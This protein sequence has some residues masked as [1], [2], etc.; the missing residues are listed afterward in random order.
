MS[1]KIDD[2]I[3][4]GLRLYHDG[5]FGEAETAGD[6]ICFIAKCGGQRDFDAL[7]LWVKEEIRKRIESYKLTRS[8]SILSSEGSMD[9]AEV[10]EIFIRRIRL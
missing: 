8:W 5:A 10:A 9:M 3:A 2:L 1:Y 6:F 4:E 7:P